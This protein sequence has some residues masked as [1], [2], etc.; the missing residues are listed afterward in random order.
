MG[1]FTGLLV[2]LEAL[3]VDLEAADPAWIFVAWRL[4]MALYC[5]GVW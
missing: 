2:D 5:Q 3:F 4:A 1:L